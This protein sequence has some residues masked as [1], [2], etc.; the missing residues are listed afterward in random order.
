MEGLA[1]RKRSQQQAGL[2][3]KSGRGARGAFSP[4]DPTRP[5]A[6][7]AAPPPAPLR[8]DV[9]ASYGAGA[10]GGL[11]YLNLL[12]KTLEGFAGGGGSAAAAAGQPRLLIPVILTLGYN[13]YN[14]LLAADTGLTLQLL[15]MLVGFFTYKGAV[16]ARQSLALFSELSSG[17]SSSGGSSGS[18]VGRAEDGEG[19]GDEAASVDR[20]FANK[21]LRG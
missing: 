20:A 7:H 12:N 19:G 9:A 16:V 3:L 11:V 18:G 1:G 13:R 14:T 5:P 17:Y 21:V 4:L 10:L 15:P 8:R 6:A 2:R